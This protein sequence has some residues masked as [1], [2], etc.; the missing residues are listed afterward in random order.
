MTQHARVRRAEFF[1]PLIRSSAE[2]VRDV[3]V[4]SVFGDVQPLEIREPQQAVDILVVGRKYPVCF[5][6]AWPAGP[7]GT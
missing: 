2:G 3:I 7:D 6:E 4:I 5:L 1:H